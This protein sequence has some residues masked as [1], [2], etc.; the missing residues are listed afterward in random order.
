[1]SVLKVE[2][3]IILSITL[4]VSLIATI[5]NTLDNVTVSIC[6]VIMCLTSH[7]M[8]ILVSESAR[9]I[10]K[11]SLGE[12]RGKIFILLIADTCNKQRGK[13]TLFRPQ[14]S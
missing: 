5:L 2:T 13:C 7:C 12:I 8:I 1:M 3:D 14:N 6:N 10:L 4:T 9:L 11:I